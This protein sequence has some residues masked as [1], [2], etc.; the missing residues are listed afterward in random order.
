[1]VLTHDIFVY[2]QC[3]QCVF[4]SNLW[5][6]RIYWTQ[7]YEGIKSEG[8]QKFY[9]LFKSYLTIQFWD[10]FPRPQHGRSKD[11][12]IL[13]I[14]F[15]VTCNFKTQTQNTNHINR[16]SAL[17]SSLSLL[18]SKREGS[19]NYF[20]GGLLTFLF[21]YFLW[22]FWFSWCFLSMYQSSTVFKQ[23]CS[24]NTFNEG[25]TL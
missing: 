13:S 24:E 3:I 20:C 6:V 12:N 16:L 11:Y 23:Y 17:E 19:S 14:Y 8:L 2:L 9:F 10:I 1:M 21:L 22:G 5:E 4:C 15:L 18:V 25:Q 7:H